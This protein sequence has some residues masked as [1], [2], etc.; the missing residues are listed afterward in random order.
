MRRS[1][2]LVPAL[3]GA[4]WSISFSWASLHAQDAGDSAVRCRGEE[5]FVAAPDSSTSS[6]YSEETIAYARLEGRV[7]D[8]ITGDG[9]DEAT[10]TL[11]S[12]GLEVVTHPDGHFRLSSV[13]P[14]PRSLEVRHAAYAMQRTCLDLP[15]ARSVLLLLTLD[16]EPIPL[17]PLSVRIDD[18]RPRWLEGTGFYRRMAAAE[19]IFITRSEIVEEDP[20]RLTELFRGRLG[21][22]VRGGQLVP[23][24]APTTMLTGEC[25][26]Q[27]FVDG[28]RMQL[29]LG[30]DTFQPG[31]VEAIEAYFGAPRLPAQFNVG[32][33]AC[34]AVVVWRRLR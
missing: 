33:A 29:P 9:I 3:T 19:G 17:E 14:G 1:L 20:S 8:G 5:V 7:A 18:V 2:V 32:R 6:S 10:I 25:P 34:G 13:P 28:R 23:R 15:S 22:T 21:V 30:L 11:P 27:Y 31:D 12:A 24:H 26:I 16:P 4:L